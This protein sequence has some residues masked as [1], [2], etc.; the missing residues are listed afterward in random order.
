MIRLPKALTFILAILVLN[1]GALMLPSS[2]VKAK[3]VSG[4]ITNVN[5]GKCL[6]LVANGKHNGAVAN[7]W[8][9]NSSRAPSQ[10]WIVE[11]IGK[12][13]VRRKY[14]QKF[15]IR[16]LHAPT[17][18]LSVNQDEGYGNGSHFILWTC[19]GDIPAQA[20]TVL[21]SLTPGSSVI[22]LK[23][24]ARC[25]GVD[26]RDTQ[27][28]YGGIN[29]WNC[30]NHSSQFWRITTNDRLSDQTST[31]LVGRSPS[32]PLLLLSTDLCSGVYVTTLTDRGKYPNPTDL[33]LQVTGNTPCKT[34]TRVKYVKYWWGDPTYTR[35]YEDTGFTLLT[36]K[37]VHRCWT[38]IGAQR[39]DGT[40][41]TR[42]MLNE[43]PLKNK[44]IPGC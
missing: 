5:S 23:H 19:Q 15:R 37:N 10:K 39:R 3:M 44:K 14:Q 20:F 22:K 32:F 36:L 27:N 2:G 34:R 8:T 12:I 30:V 33:S 1:I 31:V 21:P 13:E 4:T 42:Y 41:F 38:E 35:Y 25:L 40:W 9:C 26:G 43:V 28:T 11:P 29:Q 18:C 6:S 16:S 24:N 7:Q 17:K